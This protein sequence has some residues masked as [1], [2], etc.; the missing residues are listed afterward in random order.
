MK[1][2]IQDFNFGIRQLRRNPGFAAIAVITIALGIGVTTAMFS[3]VNAVLL[4]PLPFH[5]PDRLL[6]VG[7]YDTRLGVPQNDLGS[8]SYP[9]VVDI[10]DRNRSL[11]DI[12]A[13]DFDQAALTGAGEPRHVNVSHVNA[14]MFPILGVQ[15]Y[16][17]RTFTPEED[18]PGRHLAVLSYKFWRTSFNGSR[19]VI[20]R[21]IELNGRAYSIVGVMPPG[22]Q[23]PIT[24]DAR[25]LWITL[26]EREQVDMPGDTPATGQRGNHVF[27]A[28]ARLRD[29]ITLEQ[30]NA[31]L[32]SI[33]QALAREYPNSNSHN[34]ITAITELEV[35]VGNLRTP[36][37]VLLAAVVLV[38]LIACAN[39]ANLLLVRGS[40]R[41]REI[42][43]RAALGATRFRLIRQLVT[44]SVTLSIAG[45]ALGVLSAYWMI[46]GVLHLYPENLPRADQ[47]G[48]DFRVLLFSAALAIVS[49]ILFGLVPS[50][51]S[52]SSVLAANI[53]SGSRTA[54]ASR[55]HNRL[56][57]G[58][59]I[60]ETAVGVMLLIGAGLLLRS[61]YRLSHV[62][63]G[64]DPNHLLTANFDL[65][66]VRYNPDQQDRFI[67]DLIS[68]VSHLPG[69]VAAAG[70]LPLPLSNNR[71]AISFNLVDHPV[72]EANEPSAGFHVVTPGFFETMQMP[73]MRGRFFDERDQRNGEPVMI[74]SAAFARKFFPNEDPVGK[75]IRIGA[76]EGPSREKYKTREVV[77]VVGDLRTDALDQDPIP[78]YYVPLSQLMFGPPTLVVRAAGEPM[79]MSSEIGKVLRS[80]DAE[81]PLYDVRTMTDYLALDLGRARFQTVLL[82]L[83]SGIA[84]L[85]TGVG[86][87]GVMAQSVAQRTQEIGIRMALGASREDVRA[88]VL[89]HGTLLSIAGT[90]IGVVSALALAQLIESLLYQIPPRDPMTYVGVCAILALVALLASYVPA[91]RAT[92]LD[93]MVALRYE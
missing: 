21:S 32:K 41:A 25:D 93:P 14:S 36:L 18:Q 29:G 48:I 19:D 24:S 73:L 38:L 67:N 60:A 40:D 1:T 11:K 68:R 22:F 79:A 46:W 53:R 92:R 34:G 13:Y 88:M 86:L 82:G 42:G 15:A 63:L 70:A 78:T 9:D 75:K 17:G 10:R 35:L 49:G 59:V 55:G 2:L 84:L 83:F 44:E 47:V 77:G 50:L 6:A 57:S 69:V 76:G 65:S 43:V 87:Y 64:F 74:I 3:V 85:L 8:V 61:L 80:M 91:L 28:V 72:P 37:V 51:H 71:F 4:R 81:A 66:D 89:R 31:D 39:V 45:S 54:T 56:R 5:Q 62:D 20:G 30:A 7:E 26:A 12:A 27:A 58:L 90:A 52:A 33:S 23:F 16:L